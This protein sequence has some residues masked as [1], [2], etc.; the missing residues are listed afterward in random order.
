MESL[1]VAL[2]INCGYARVCIYQ[3]SNPNRSGPN[4]R[5]SIDTTQR[6]ANFRA[7]FDSDNHL[8]EEDFSVRGRKNMTK[9]D[10]HCDKI[11][12]CYRLKF[13][14]GGD[15]QSYLDTFSH[16]KW[17]ELPDSEKEMH[18]ISK[19]IRCFQL[20]KESQ[21]S[22]PLN[23][24]FNYTPVATPSVATPSVATSSSQSFINKDAARGAFQKVGANK[25][26]DKLVA[27]FREFYEEDLGRSFTESM[28]K[29]KSSGLET[30][31]TKKE[32]R[33][34]KVK[35][36][37]ECIKEI[38]VQFADNAATSMLGQCES[39]RSY[40]RKRLAQSFQ[41]PQPAKKIKSHS[42][43]FSSV[44]WSKEDL[45]ESV[46]NWPPDTVINWSQVARENG[47]SGGNAGQVAKEFIEKEGIDTSHLKTPT[48]KRTMRP[49]MK[50]LPGTGVSIPSNPSIGDIETEIKSLISS[51][52]YL[53]GQEC[54][55]YTLKK[56]SMVDGVMT[57]RDVVIQG[58]KV[59]LTDIRQRLLDRQLK[60]MRLT[61][62]S[63]I[64]T[65]TKPQ[66]VKRLNVKCD[67]K[68]EE[69]LREL[70]REAQTSRSS[71]H[72]AR[73]CLNT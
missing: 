6:A 57:P 33:K 5:M 13:R 51:G 64:D 31:K 25:F 3:N 41:S 42:P 1:Q 58:R 38:N 53:L 18:S 69:E 52:K 30:K 71:L 28:S 29:T 26:D 22:F 39:K 68:S 15:R 59:P 14:R 4:A 16:S 63:V 54:A 47:I 7:M 35:I 46:E 34:Y 55:P 62:D 50:K 44:D 56:Y 20:H 32:K 49:K 10:R 48:R 27:Q 67:D 40:H 45:R 2:S 61:P 43:N 37:K 17:C 12:D 66:L 36:Q 60:Y 65:M 70:L 9:F 11:L 19:C 24:T 73:P 8:P 21:H 23:P 72:V